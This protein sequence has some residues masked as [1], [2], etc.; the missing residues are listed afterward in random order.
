MSP[1]GACEGR[2]AFC[3]F[4]QLGCCRRVPP[5]LFSARLMLPSAVSEQPDA[6][7]RFFVISAE[8]W[9]TRL[10]DAPVAASLRATT[11]DLW[12]IRCFPISSLMPR[13]FR[14]IDVEPIDEKKRLSDC[15]ADVLH[16]P[17]GVKVKQKLSQV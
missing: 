3:K 11:T 17:Y 14:I 12:P 8:T 2:F 7:S 5:H 13:S 6:S 15:V 9:S 16:V 4:D 10:V 1:F